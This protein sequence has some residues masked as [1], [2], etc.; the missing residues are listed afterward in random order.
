M[1]G[2]LD[3]SF[4]I[5][6]Q[7]VKGTYVRK[8]AAP[9]Q[10]PNLYNFPHA[11]P[12]IPTKSKA[13][14]TEAFPSYECQWVDPARHVASR[15][16]DPSPNMA[17]SS[18]CQSLGTLMSSTPAVLANSLMQNVSLRASAGVANE[19]FAQDYDHQTTSTY[20]MTRNLSFTL[21]PFED[22]LDGNVSPIDPT[23]QRRYRTQLQQQL[24][25]IMRNEMDRSFDAL[26]TALREMDDVTSNPLFSETTTMGPTF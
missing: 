12:S 22:S 23:N 6:R 21:N 26:L 15:L 24:Q 19:G 5:Q 14:E 11:P 3:L 20:A 13:W 9:D 1:R 7:K 25:P 18:L 10:E 8:P 17:A 16:V 2:R 4:E